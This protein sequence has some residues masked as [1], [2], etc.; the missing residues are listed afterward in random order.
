MTVYIALLRGINVGGNNIIKMQDLRRVLEAIGFSDVQTY[1]QS[2]NVLFKSNEE[3]ELLP[4]KIKHAIEIAF[5]FSITIVLRTCQELEDIIKNFPFSPQEISEAE[6]SSKAQSAYVCLLTHV[7]LQ[8]NI[9]KLDTYKTESEDYR[10]LGREV[11]LLFHNSI[12]NSKL[13]SNL[14]KL[15]VPATVRNLKTLNKLAA[16]AKAMEA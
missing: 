13:A 7:P 1:I 10:I 5:G 16:L 15:D 9:Q 8:E 6:A 3:K 14:H 12:S 11:F 2:G 4:N